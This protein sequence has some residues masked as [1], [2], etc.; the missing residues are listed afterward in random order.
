[1][2][3]AFQLESLRILVRGSRLEERV[4]FGLF[5]GGRCEGERRSLAQRFSKR[6]EWGR[7]QTRRTMGLSPVRERSRGRA[8]LNGGRTKWIWRGA[9]R[10]LR[11]KCVHE[12]EIASRDADAGVNWLIWGTLLRGFASRRTPLAA[13]CEGFGRREGTPRGRI[14]ASACGRARRRTR[15]GGACPLRSGRCS[16]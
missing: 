3:V 14:A 8:A 12:K 10:Q 9:P 4:Y 1:M 2:G 15:A 5:R 16:S 13:R 7:A 11:R 6:C